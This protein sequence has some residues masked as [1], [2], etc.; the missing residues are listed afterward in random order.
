MFPL[1]RPAKYPKPLTSILLVPSTHTAPLTFIP[2][3][4]I[5]PAVD[6][7]LFTTPPLTTDNPG[8]HNSST[9]NVLPETV[10]GTDEVTDPFTAHLPPVGQIQRHTHKKPP[11]HFHPPTAA[12]YRRRL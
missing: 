9:A 8:A 10:T 1:V 7:K 3:L 5:W 2:S 12:D 11:T 6:A 4:C